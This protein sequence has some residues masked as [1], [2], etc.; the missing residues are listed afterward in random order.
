MKKYLFFLTLTTLM[1]SSAFAGLVIETCE[2]TVQSKNSQSIKTYTKS[3]SVWPANLNGQYVITDQRVKIDYQK[4]ESKSESEP[5]DRFQWQLEISLPNNELLLY[6]R[7][8]GLKRN[9]LLNLPDGTQV[10][11]YCYFDA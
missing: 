2:W 5:V 8:I 11:A 10:K 4:E 3:V 1:S 7:G 9:F 6:L